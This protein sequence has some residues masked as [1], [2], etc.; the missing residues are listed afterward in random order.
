[1]AARGPRASF[2]H[3]FCA[4]WIALVSPRPPVG[5][6]RCAAS[7][8]RNTR[9]TLNADAITASTDQRVILWI[10]IGRSPIP[11]AL[12]TSASTCAS[13]SARVDR[14][15]EVDHPLLRLR[16]P[17]LG[18]HRDH[19]H[20]HA[21]LRRVDPAD[22]HVRVARPAARSPP[23]RAASPSASPRRAPRTPRRSGAATRRP[24]SAPSR[25]SQRTVYSRPDAVVA[26]HGAHASLVLLEVDQLVVEADPPGESSS[27]R[28]FS[29]GSRRICGRFVLPPRARGA[30]GLVRLHRRPRTPAAASAP[31][32]VG[33]RTG[34]AGV[35]GR[36]RHLLG[37]A[38]CARAIASADPD[39]LEHLH[40]PLVEHVRLRQLRRARAAR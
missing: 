8:S 28:A 35:E 26:D 18:P 31:P 5:G 17:V 27:A 19:H 30:P 9:P 11:S 40:R 37:A 39:V 20:Q 14:V 12:R 3:R 29:S 6:W 15:V 10:S 13:V 23:T 25:Y 22:Q 16:T 34:E 33:V 4:S 7:P 24:P 1:M 21:R 38:C 32:V 36:R 2:Q